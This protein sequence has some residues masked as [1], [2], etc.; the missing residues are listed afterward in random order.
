MAL[1]SVRRLLSRAVAVA[2]PAL[3]S[4]VSAWSPIGIKSNF[5]PTATRFGGLATANFAPNLL[6]ALSRLGR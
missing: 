1:Q 2:S 6:A 3:V 5:A 4:E